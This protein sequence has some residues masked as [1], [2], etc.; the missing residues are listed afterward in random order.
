MAPAD[1]V[2]DAVDAAEEQEARQRDVDTEEHGENVG[3]APARERP[4]PVRQ[5][6]TPGIR[7]RLHCHPYANENEKVVPGARRPALGGCSERQRNENESGYGSDTRECE[8]ICPQAVNQVH[9]EHRGAEQVAAGGA[10]ARSEAIL[11]AARGKKQHHQK[12]KRESR[13][14]GGERLAAVAEPRGVQRSGQSQHGPETEHGERAELARGGQARIVTERNGGPNSTN[15]EAA[16]IHRLDAGPCVRTD[17]SDALLRLL[18]ES[19][20]EEIVVTDCLV[21][22]GRDA[23]G[24]AIHFFGGGVVCPGDGKIA[25]K[26]NRAQRYRQADDSARGGDFWHGPAVSRAGVCAGLSLVAVDGFAARGR[27]QYSWAL[28]DAHGSVVLGHW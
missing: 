9:K 19:G 18:D 28:D 23:A 12:E 25:R 6:P 26:G 10:E 21:A 4:E 7:Q 3:E 11:H 17:V 14:R 22:A 5:R 20:G 27:A 2:A 13:E 16:G 15:G 24:A 8:S 1:G